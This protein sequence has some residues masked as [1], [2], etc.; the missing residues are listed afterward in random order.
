MVRAV[1]RF[2]RAAQPGEGCRRGLR[3]P[4]EMALYKRMKMR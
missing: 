1:P 3:R 4:A 2:N